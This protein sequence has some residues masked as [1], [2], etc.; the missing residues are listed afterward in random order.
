MYG[1]LRIFGDIL[2]K[3][4]MHIGGNG[5]FAAI[6][7]VDSPVIR[8]ATTNLPMIPGSSLKGKIRSLLQK[9]QITVSFLLNLDC[10]LNFLGSN[11]FFV[12]DLYIASWSANNIFLVLIKFLAFSKSFVSFIFFIFSNNIP[13]F[14]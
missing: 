7:A 3:T 8:D 2:V 11:F 1:K 9:W 12:V 6:G 10:S 4:G 13:A 5:A 14:I